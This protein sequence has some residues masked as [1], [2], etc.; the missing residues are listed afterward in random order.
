[1][2]VLSLGVGGSD[3]HCM[4]HTTRTTLTAVHLMSEQSVAASIGTTLRCADERLHC[5]DMA[6]RF[7]LV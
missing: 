1:M 5:S 2:G 3:E 7:Y 6:E 4:H